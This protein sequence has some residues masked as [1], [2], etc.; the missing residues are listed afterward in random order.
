MLVES[1]DLLPHH[2][3]PTESARNEPCRPYNCGASVAGRPTG[4][5][6]GAGSAAVEARWGGGQRRR[7]APAAKTGC[8]RTRRTR[9][10]PISIIWAL[11]GLVIA[12]AFAVG[13]LLYSRGTLAEARRL[14]EE[15]GVEEDVER[16]SAEQ[17][18][19]TILLAA[20][21][22][23][24]RRRD[25]A[26]AD[27]RAR[28]AD[29]ARLEQRASQREESLERRFRELE[30]NEQRLGRRET[31]LEATR[32][33]LEE[34]R[35][36]IG[37]ELQRVAGLSQ[38]EAR[39][40]VL[41]AVEGE[42]QPEI[43]ERIRRAEAQVREEAAERTR[44]ILVTAMQ[45]QASELTGE[46]VVT[47]MHLPSD[48]LKGRIIGREGRNIRA[49]E[50]ATGVDVIVDDTPEAIV[51][52]AFDPVRREVARNALE[53][54][55]SD[56]RIHPARIE[57]MVTKARNEL[58]Q[59]IRQDGEAACQ[60]LGITGVHHELAK[61]LGTLRFRSSYGQNVLAHS[62]DAA[63][64]AGI[65]AAEIGYDEQLAKEAAL[66]HDIGKAVEADV[67]GPHAIV[68][69][70][71]LQ[72]L[73]RP[74]PVVQAVRAHHYDDEPRSTLAFIVMTADAISAA[75]QGARRET[76]ASSIKRFE[77]IEAIANE[78]DG[79]ERSFAV[80]AGKELRVMVKPGQ[81]DDDAA[82]VMAR[83]IAKRLH[84][85]GSY[86]GRIKVV[87]LRETRSVEYAK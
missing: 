86:E 32:Q 51:L 8:R 52:S 55:F 49:L 76:L 56:G 65:L 1:G 42:M 58:T 68:G 77:R 34:E 63:Q 59:Q 44:E 28:R 13:A 71:I 83:Q 30:Q 66:F 12:V 23:A 10:T 85:E 41:R 21:E 73:G 57:E 5:W 18:R 38:A 16:R 29:V 17:E 81:V 47:V 4:T 31:E 19:Q 62:M 48:E 80:Q 60:E 64:V 75:R 45:R 70:E 78:F 36:S 87:V 43:A 24:A 35:E 69:G 79:V 72:R 14:R 7:T 20:K 33:S 50:A 15:R 22:E 54:L 25:E 39:A 82:Q 84:A 74:A 61:L 26:E 40:E 46:A 37:Q 11:I 67:D 2:L 3:K 6:G 9:F 53:R 27:V